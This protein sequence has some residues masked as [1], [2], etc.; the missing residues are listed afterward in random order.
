MQKGPVVQTGP[1]EFGS[2]HALRRA[3]G[4]SAGETQNCFRSESPASLYYSTRSKP[5]GPVKALNPQERIW[6]AQPVRRTF[7]RT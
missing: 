5:L 4:R 1:E 2:L 6:T 7:Y 3:Q